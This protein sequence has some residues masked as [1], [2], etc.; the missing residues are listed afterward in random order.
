VGAVL[1]GGAALL[2]A[3]SLFWAAMVGGAMTGGAVYVARAI[4]FETN[5]ED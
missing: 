1:A 4:M 5:S 3:P 2:L